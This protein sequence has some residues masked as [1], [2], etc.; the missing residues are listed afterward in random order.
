MQSVGTVLAP[1]F[2]RH[3]GTDQLSGMR[4]TGSNHCL[5]PRISAPSWDDWI[6]MQLGFG[7]RGGSRQVALTAESQSVGSKLS[8]RSPQYLAGLLSLRFNEHVRHALPSGAC[9]WK[10]YYKF[11]SGRSSHGN[12]QD[13]KGR[14]GVLGFHLAFLGNFRRLNPSTTSCLVTPRH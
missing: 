7:I 6:S 1:S 13:L 4:K 11:V 8:N 10:G 5:F 9:R 12:S 3:E 14:R 2:G